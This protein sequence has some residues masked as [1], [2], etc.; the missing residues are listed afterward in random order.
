MLLLLLLML[1]LLMLQKLWL[2][3][4]SITVALL[5]DGYNYKYDISLPLHSYYDIVD[6]MRARLKGAGATRICGYGHVMDGESDTC[7]FNSLAHAPV[8]SVCATDT[9]W[10]VSA[11]L[12]C[13]TTLYMRL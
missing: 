2:L 6:V 4:E 8:T 1:L 11:T 7:V 10:T 12:V 5:D 3:R 13:S 9:S